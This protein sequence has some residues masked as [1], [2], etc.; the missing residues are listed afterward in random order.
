MNSLKAI[1]TEYEENIMT[2]I[3]V[4]LCFRQHVRGV[5]VPPI[6]FEEIDRPTD[7]CSTG[8]P[9]RRPEPTNDKWYVGPT[10]YIL[11]L[12][13]SLGW[14]FIAGLGMSFISMSGKNYKI[15]GDR[16]DMTIAVYWG[17]KQHQNKRKLKKQLLCPTWHHS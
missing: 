10:L 5:R 3:G 16:P 17:I 13:C 7:H 1:A 12:S 2:W 8:S 9:L 11:S 15:G 14:C 4:F 6:G